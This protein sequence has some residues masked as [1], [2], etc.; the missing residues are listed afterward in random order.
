MREW[1]RVSEYAE[2]AGLTARGALKRLH[3]KNSQFNGR[4]LR[5]SSPSGP[6]EVSV[7]VLSEGSAQ[8]ARAETREDELAALRERLDSLDLR[9]IG[10]RDSL[11]AWRAKLSKRLD[12]I[13]TEPEQNRNS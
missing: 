10:V 8:R 6:W 9:L 12:A 1:I 11:R 3:V 5:R 13:G 7:L 4:L 2:H